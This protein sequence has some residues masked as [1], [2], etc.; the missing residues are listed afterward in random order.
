MEAEGDDAPARPGRQ[1]GVGIAPVN[2]GLGLFQPHGAADDLLHERDELGMSRVLQQRRVVLDE[3]AD[4]D[5]V[6][7]PAVDIDTARGGIRLGL[8]AVERLFYA[9]DLVGAQYVV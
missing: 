6:L 2:D 4:V 1:V 8:E 3:V 9:R 5:V 7:V